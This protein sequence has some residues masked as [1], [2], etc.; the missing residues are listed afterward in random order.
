MCW[1]LY[2]VSFIFLYKGM[3]TWRLVETQQ[4]LNY[5]KTLLKLLCINYLEF[6]NNFHIL[7]I[8]ESDLFCIVNTTN[9]ISSCLLVFSANYGLAL[10]IT[11]ETKLEISRHVVQR[12]WSK[13]G[14][15]KGHEMHTGYL[16]SMTGFEI[17]SAL[18]LD[19][20]EIASKSKIKLKERVKV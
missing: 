7:E 17:K 5:V 16:E 15:K 10:I 8:L 4:H 13:N 6:F 9:C 14:L 2:N 1:H 20:F 11:S 18:S 12:F 3:K 19:R